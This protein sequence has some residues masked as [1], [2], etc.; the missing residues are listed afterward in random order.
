ME[1]RS[2]P[3]IENSITFFH[4]FETNHSVSSPTS[5]CAKN[6]DKNWGSKMF[7]TPCRHIED[8]VQTQCKQHSKEMSGQKHFCLKAFLANKE[9]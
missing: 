9:C 3:S 2:N 6:Y 1:V 5:L 4:F 7:L 8:T